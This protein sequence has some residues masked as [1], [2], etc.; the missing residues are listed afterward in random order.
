MMYLIHVRISSGRHFPRASVARRVDEAVRAVLP[1]TVRV[2]ARGRDSGIDLVVN[3]VAIQAKWV[4]EGGLRQVGEVLA[5]KRNRP[6]IV[7]A[8]RLSPG[9]RDAL[10]H[11]GVGW[12]DESGAAE[13]ALGSLVVSKSGHPPPPPEKSARWTPAVLAVAEALLCGSKATVA[14]VQETTR[15]SSGG[16]TKALAVLSGLG[17][18][19]SKAARG[20]GSAREIV[21][22]NELLD[23]YAAAAAAMPPAPSVRVGVTW[24]EITMGL[25][26]LG[27]QWD[28]AGLAWAATGAAAASVIA[29]YITSVTTADVYVDARTI[30]SLTAAAALVGLHPIEGGRLVLRPFPTVTARLLA[31]D[32][33]GLRVAPW[34]RVFVDLKTAG[35]RGEEAAEH[36][37]E[38]QRGR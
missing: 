4:G 14:A 29:P 18:L 38:L 33:G 10:S 8:R 1:R 25:S 31:D 3:G 27:K 30:A 28:E 22:D 26:E 13:V 36:L 37:R 16:S 6:D 11:A 34:P 19:T 15:L 7:V 24:R 20:R 21:N 2:K 9:A 32:T 23:A 12:I 5:L 17:L 35:V